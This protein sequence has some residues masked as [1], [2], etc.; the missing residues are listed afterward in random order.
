MLD[1]SAAVLIPPK[2]LKVN[3]TRNQFGKKLLKKRGCICK[4]SKYFRVAAFGNREMDWITPVVY[5]Q[6]S[7]SHWFK[8]SQIQTAVSFSVY[9]AKTITTIGA[10]WPLCWLG[11]DK[12]PLSY[13]Q[14]WSLQ[15]GI[16]ALLS[17]W[18][19]GFCKCCTCCVDVWRSQLCQSGTFHQH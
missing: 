1:L 16:E 13:P 14:M 19:G 6:P 15:V 10:N 4:V 8:S 7:S 9:I 11:T 12:S 18:L 2:Y 17:R 5:T 3:K